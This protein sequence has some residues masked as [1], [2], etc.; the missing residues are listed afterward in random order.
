MITAFPN[1]A[2]SK[3][4]LNRIC[5]KI[6]ADGTIARKTGSGHRKS[7]GTVRNIRR[8][9]ELICSQED[10]AQ[11]RKS[12][13]EI[14][15]E[16]GISRRTVQCIVKHDLQLQTYKRVIGQVIN[17]NCKLKRLQRSQQLLDRFPNERSVRSIWFT[18][19][20]TNVYVYCV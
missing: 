16:T 7:V 8:A 2:W 14:E 17:E 10:N 15:R 3:T 11:S 18:D 13:W 9:S 19:E 4:N 20:K 5:K 1:K 6:D 12:T